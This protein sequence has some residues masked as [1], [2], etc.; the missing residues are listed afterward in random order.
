MV[1]S[2]GFTAMFT[3]PYTH[4]QLTKMERQWATLADSAA[5][6]MQHANFPSKYWGLAMRTTV[7]L[8]NT[9]ITLAAS[10][11]SGGVI[12][13]FFMAPMLTSLT[14]R[15]SDALHTSVWKTNIEPSFPP[16]PF[17]VCSSGTAMTV[18]AI[19]FST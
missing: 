13:V 8:R 4:N 10:G 16:R 14:S 9:L 11:G 12:S 15:F 1:S 5:A 6:M 17:V 7:Y 2:F 19:G 18:P 3:A